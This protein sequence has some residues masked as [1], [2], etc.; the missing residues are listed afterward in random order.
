M[1]LR[2]QCD[3]ELYLS[4]FQNPLKR[5][6]R[7]GIP[8]LLKSRPGVQLITASG[9]EFE[10]EQ[11]G[12]LIRLI[13][14]FVIHQT[15]G[16]TEVD[17]VAALK[18]A[19]TP[20]FILQPEIK[21]QSLRAVSLTN[22]GLSQVE[23]A[24]I[25]ELSGLIPDVLYVHAPSPGEYEI[26]PD[27]SR[28]RIADGDKRS[29]ISVIDLKNVTEANASYSAEVCLYALRATG[30]RYAQDVGAVHT[31]RGCPTTTKPASR[32]RCYQTLLGA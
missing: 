21:P 25:P 7:F 15:D 3:H 30:R 20:S 17:P 29:G 11:Y 19:S 22:L 23:Q 32:Q 2:T 8:V 13:S 6:Q 10:Y 14:E 18:A 12:E 31:T 27:G 28:K 24:A 26:T 1:Y 16:R 4:L 5:C 9:H